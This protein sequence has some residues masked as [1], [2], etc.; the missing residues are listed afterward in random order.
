MMMMSKKSKNWMASKSAAADREE[1][2]SSSLQGWPGYRTRA[3][4]SGLD[5]MDSRAEAGHI[6]GVLIRQFFTLQIKTKNPIHLILLGIMG[7]LLVL[8]FIAVV[9]ET[10]RG[11]SQ[12]ASI[13]IIFILTGIIGLA[14]FANLIKN[15]VR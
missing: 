1:D 5:P 7:L 11:N 6:S 3:G 14:A 15:L 9:S 10:M 4:R 13:W 12:D 2:D 8:P